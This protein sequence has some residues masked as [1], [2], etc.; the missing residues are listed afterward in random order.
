MPTESASTQA[1]QLVRTLF[2]HIHGNLGILR[3]SIEELKPDPES[4]P[5][6][7]IWDVTCSFFETIGSSAPTRYFAKVRLDDRTVTIKKLGTNEVAPEQKYKF[8]P[9]EAKAEE[10]KTDAITGT[11]K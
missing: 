2:E 10:P 5:E 9:E 7:K 8:A 4:N 1:V 3:F 6:S 11:P